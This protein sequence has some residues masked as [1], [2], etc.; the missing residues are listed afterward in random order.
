MP[1]PIRPGAAGLRMVTDASSMDA[2]TGA[3]GALNGSAVATLH[4]GR[5]FLTDSKTRRARLRELE[6]QLVR[7]RV[8]L[9][10]AME[11]PRLGKERG[12]KQ[13]YQFAAPKPREASE[14]GATRN[15]RR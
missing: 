11:G 13:I 10:E 8:H 15:A 1:A 3:L 5:G 6:K 7:T 2:A 4:G 14:T 12:S 9:S